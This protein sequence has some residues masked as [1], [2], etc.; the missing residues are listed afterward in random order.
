MLNKASFKVCDINNF[1]FGKYDLIVSNPPYIPTKEIKNLSKE[2]TDYEPLSALNGGIDGL[3]LIKI[4]I[5]KSSRLLKRSGILA[6]EVGNH[7]YKRVSNI[8][9]EN[10][11]REIVK[12]YDYNFNVRCIINTK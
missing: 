12:V 10:G 11:F 8:L 6:I 3:D 7:Q 9:K 4:V 2:I 5:Y 1:C